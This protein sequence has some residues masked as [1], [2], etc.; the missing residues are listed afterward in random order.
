M[1]LQ[2]VTKRLAALE[3]RVATMILPGIAQRSEGSKTVARF[4]DK[5][6]DGQPFESPA[7]SHI[8][9][10]G[11]KGGG[12]S[13]YSKIGDGEPVYVISPGGELGKHSRIMPAG[14]VDDHPAPGTAEQDGEIM[15]FGD[16]KI[17]VR[18]DGTMIQK[19]E[20]SV[21]L[22]NDG[23]MA[24]SSKGSITVSGKDITLDGP[25]SMPKG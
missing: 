14:P 5:G 12:V 21:L 16:A 19:G 8:A 13:R 10:S 7:L 6:V 11:K 9:S 22:K 24:L 20:Q 1:N 15:E 25:V 4:D 23:T 17:S 2:E 3:R 18:P